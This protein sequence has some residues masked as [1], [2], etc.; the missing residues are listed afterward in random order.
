MATAKQMVREVLEQMP[1]DCS[2][3]D[4]QYQLYLRQKLDR[5]RQAAAEGRVVSHAEVKERLSKWAGR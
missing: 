3:E 1:D 2:L 5:S 4:V